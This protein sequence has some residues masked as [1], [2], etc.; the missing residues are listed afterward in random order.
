MIRHKKFLYIIT[1]NSK[2]I[3]MRGK[4]DEHE[5]LNSWIYPFQ[6]AWA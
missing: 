6:Q 3:K 4:N 2:T 5:E 1:P